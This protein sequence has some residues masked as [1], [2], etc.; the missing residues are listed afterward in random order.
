MRKELILFAIAFTFLNLE[1]RA[2]ISDTIT[3]TTAVP[4]DEDEPGE[5][6]ISDI[7]EVAPEFIGEIAKFSQY[8]NNNFNFPKGRKEPISIYII[9][10]VE[11]DGS[12]SNIKLL[13]DLGKG[14]AQEVVRV[15]SKSPKWKPG[16]NNGRAARTYFRLPLKIQSK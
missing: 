9:F 7:V 4:R 3:E 11:K 10:V 15:I 8:V 14:V 5:N 1:S 6:A 13:R 16:I 2:Q 12:L